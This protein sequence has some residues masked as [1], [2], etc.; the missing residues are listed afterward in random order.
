MR[1]DLLRQVATA[2]KHGRPFDLPDDGFVYE[3]RY[4]GYVQ[5]KQRPR[6]MKSG[7]TYTPKE[8]VIFENNIRQ[9]VS[10]DMKARKITRLVGAISVQVDIDDTAYD[11][12]STSKKLICS[13]GYFYDDHGDLD[14]KF[15]AVGDA[16]NG[17][18]Y[19]DDSQ[20]VEAIQTRAF[21]KKEGFLL[22][23]RTIPS[24]TRAEVLVL[25][26]LLRKI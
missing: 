7:R 24:L 15:K 12:W 2:I 4:N 23:V 11:S 1:T 16:L 5:P 14:N 18:L 9:L 22:T 20:I 26:E 10:A 13:R 19:K 6:V 3:F 21:S 8:T 17:V 25:E